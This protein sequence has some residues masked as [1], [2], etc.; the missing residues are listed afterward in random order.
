M[1]LVEQA[2][3]VPVIRLHPLDNVVVASRRL[4]KGAAAGREGVVTLDAIPAGHKLAV[5]PVVAVAVLQA[6]A[7]A[8]SA[9]YPVPATPTGLPSGIEALQTYVG[10]SLCDPVAK[11]GV[12]AF[13][14]LVLSTYSG[15]TDLGIVRDCGS[16]GQSEHKEGR[17]WDWGVSVSNATQKAQADTLIAWLLKI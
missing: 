6:A 11:P 3:E 16:G 10:Q 2:A 9:A 7:P 8:A 17:A 5:V 4:S 1:A 13:R 12:A 15:T 14:S